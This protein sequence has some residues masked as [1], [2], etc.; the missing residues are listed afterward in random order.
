[1]EAP[2]RSVT[3]GAAYGSSGCEECG[4]AEIDPSLKSAFGIS[5]CVRCRR[6]SADYKLLSR[7]ASKD[8]FLL[9]DS[10]FTM[11]KFMTKENPR[12]AKW[13][14]VQLYLQRQL[15]ALSYAKHGN[16]EGLE[17][18][19]ALRAAKRAERQAAARGTKRQTMSELAT[20][21]GESGEFLELSTG[22]SVPIAYLQQQSS[23][24]LGSA[25]RRRAGTTS[26]STAQSAAAAAS[27]SGSG[28]S[29]VGAALGISLALPPLG[30]AGYQS[31]ARTAQ[32]RQGGGREAPAP[33]PGK[34]AGVSRDRSCATH[35]APATPHITG[36]DI[37]F[38]EL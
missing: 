2:V 33:A 3:A 28:G 24:P 8:V 4:A 1:M 6:Q 20:G 16:L 37:D 25:K 21:G 15:R 11:L 19:R 22:V 12:N 23:A 18:E 13:K 29:L 36:G 5:V 17:A 10:D 38:D 32:S 31:A 30:A 14:P 7:T 35:K 34:G 26:A 27:D 9:S